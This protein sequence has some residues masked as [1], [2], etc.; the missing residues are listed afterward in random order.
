MWQQKYLLSLKK[1]KD[2]IIKIN[3]FF[4]KVQFRIVIALSYYSIHYIIW[5]V[6]YTNVDDYKGLHD[7]VKP[8][9]VF[10]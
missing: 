10:S 5:E 1:Y 4:G 2:L 7:E 6:N 3:P 8:L 9:R